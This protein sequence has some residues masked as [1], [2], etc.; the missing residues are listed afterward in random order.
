MFPASVSGLY[1]MTL[2][3]E[4]VPMDGVCKLSET[5]D[6]IGV[7]ARDAEDLIS[8]AEILLSMGDVE[9]L[10]SL[11]KDSSVS[12]LWKGLS[13]GILDSDWAADSEKWGAADV[14]RPKSTGPSTSAVRCV[15][16]TDSDHFAE[17]QVR[18]GSAQDARSR[19]SRRLP[20]E[21]S[22]KPKHAQIR[23]REYLDHCL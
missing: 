14:V 17:R 11:L 9:G 3:F 2:P 15:S 21:R 23:G 1:G 16:N 19:C 18:R 13:I 12:E 4:S 8:L 22:P 5:F 7:M 6:R 20:A 10:S